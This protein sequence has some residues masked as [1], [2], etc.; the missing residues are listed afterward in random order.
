MTTKPKPP[1]LCDRCPLT[2]IHAAAVR[3][4][5]KERERERVDKAK[6]LA[7]IKRRHP[8]M[9]PLEQHLLLARRAL[10]P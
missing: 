5:Q 7:T 4:W 10:H 6:A 8:T 1:L 3:Q 9:P 2:E